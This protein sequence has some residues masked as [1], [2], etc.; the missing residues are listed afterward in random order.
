MK[1]L[2]TLILVCAF[3]TSA[4]SQISRIVKRMYFD[5]DTTRKSSFVILPVLSSAPETGLEVG[6]A[7]LLSFYT[8]TSKLN[9]R[10]SNVFGYA[11]IT[12]KGQSRLSLTTSYWT[13]GNNYHLTAGISYINFPFNFYGI[14]NNTLEAN[15]DRIGQKRFKVNFTAEKKISNNLYAGIT[16]GAWDYKFRDD[17]KTGIFYTDPRVEDHGGGPSAYI[18]PTIT[19]D[20]R[21][22]NTYTTKG[23]IVNAYFQAIHGMFGNNDYKGGFF[24]I[25]YS[26]FF[27]LAPKWVL[28]LDVQEQSLTGSTSPFYLLPGLGSDELMRGY[29]NGRFRDRNM[30]AGQ[31]ELRYRLSDRIGF[32]G[33]VGGGE[34]FKSSFSTSELKPNYGGGIRYFFDVE[35]GLA[36]R[37]DYGVGQ[38][39]P[40]EKRLTGFYIAL[41]QSF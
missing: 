36:V 4:F 16:G 32:A 5:K 28:G 23:L 41:G 9:T 21:N 12:T 20:N 15:S 3:S 30:I 10:V 14:G 35:K 24:N 2:V 17:D 29:Y 39:I 25:E 1:K 37:I 6:G 34:V 31:A 38:K 33:F 40:N 18:G 19:F 27:L 11:S 13:P 8:D 7:G 26:Q 22:N